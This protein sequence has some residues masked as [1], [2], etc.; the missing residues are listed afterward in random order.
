MATSDEIRLYRGATEGQFMAIVELIGELELDDTENSI[1]NATRCINQQGYLELQN[2]VANY[3][4]RAGINHIKN[5]IREILGLPI[6]ETDLEK[7]Q[8]EYREKQPLET[9][10][11]WNCPALQDHEF[12]VV[13][14]SAKLIPLGD[15]MVT[16]VVIGTK[17]RRKAL[18][19]IRRYERD[20]LD[21]PSGDLS[22]ADDLELKPLVWRDA[23]YDHET[24]STHIFSWRK[25]DVKNNPNAVMA[26]I[27]E[28]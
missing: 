7:T 28:G 2:M 20:W 21:M 11:L 15:D 1:R 17:D 26:F 8:R 10:A 22:T 19:M 27:R 9:R 24:D 23:Q 12:E 3:Y 14:G 13:E 4:Y 16:T 6:L 25:Y 18:R 5:E